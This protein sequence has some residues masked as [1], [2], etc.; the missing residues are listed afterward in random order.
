MSLDRASQFC[1][2]VVLRI[3]VPEDDSYIHCMN[4][5]GSVEGAVNGE[6]GQEKTRGSVVLQDNQPH[7]TNLKPTGIG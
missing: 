5:M 4:L 3:Q 1:A 2:T 7:R 6:M